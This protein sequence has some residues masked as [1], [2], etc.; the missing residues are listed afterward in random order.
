MKRNYLIILLLILAQ[1]AL[2]EGDVPPTRIN[3]IYYNLDAIKRQA[4][5]TY[6][7]DYSGPVYEKTTYKGTVTIPATVSYKGITY[8]VTSISMIAFQ[9]NC[10]LRTVNLPNSILHIGSGAFEGCDKFQSLTIPKSV[11]DIEEGILSTCNA[12]TSIIV[13]KANK[14]YD[15]RNDCNAIIHTAT[16]ELI[17]GCKNTVIPNTVTRIGD[18]AFALISSL[19][20]I[21]IPNSITS[22]GS[23][24]FRDTGLKE[25]ALPNSVIYLGYAVFFSCRNLT[26]VTLS[27]SLES[28][29]PST[30]EQCDITTITIPASVESI[31]NWIF[32]ANENHISIYIQSTTPPYLDNNSFNQ[33]FWGWRFATIHVPVGYREVY[34]SS[35]SWEG[36]TIIDDIVLPESETGISTLNSNHSTLNRNIFSLSGKRLSAPRKGINI[37]N[38]KKINF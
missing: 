14:V 7:W 8:D 18:S 5:V 17:Q 6:D 3:G 23:H 33:D 12:V 25:L 15:S 22:I 20:S 11:I 32:H 34:H 2:A 9:G 10:E 38:G 13:D 26:S 29:P 31:S 1:T 35:E 4:E 21:D 36:F 24:A 16:N 28:I 27:E 30:F 37:I 19:T